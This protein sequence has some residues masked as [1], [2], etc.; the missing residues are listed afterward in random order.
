M[1]ESY[2]AKR[3]LITL[4]ALKDN[5]GSEALVRGLIRICKERHP[6]CKIV[7]SSG[8]K[9]EIQTAIPNVDAMVSRRDD[10]SKIV[11]YK[12]KFY[13]KILKDKYKAESVHYGDLIREAGKADIIFVIGAD[14]YDASYN[15]Q[16]LM[17]RINTMILKATKG[18]TVMYDC[19]LEEKHISD[20]VVA[21]MERFDYITVRESV[22]EIAFRKHFSEEKLCYFP[23]PAFAMLPEECQLPSNFTEGKMVGINLSNLITSGN[24]GV[25]A[26]K[27]IKSYCNL[28]GY[29]LNETQL[30]II[31][32]PHVMGNADLSMLR[33]LYEYYKENDRV[34]LI[35][36][37]TYNAAQ[38]KYII[39]KLSYLVTA[40]T[41]ASIAAYSMCVP[42]LVIGYSVKSI[43]IAKDL[44]GTADK[45][46]VSTNDIVTGN[47]LI[48]AFKWLVQNGDSIHSH[49]QQVI[50]EYQEKVMKTGEIM[51]G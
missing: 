8:S 42:T 7:I 22:T 39:S 34:I 18:T 26:D 50:P 11:K 9:G 41:H 40:R 13:N 27:L 51:K 32:I 28:F 5:R 48:D 43:G 1:E 46:V 33:K 2:M 3:I 44:F 36:D 47:E 37:E 23:D 10:T 45:Y 31:L 16:G 6:D 49:L 14:N 30:Q 25:D 4:N 19:S 17:Q 21:D 24:Y 38:L 12:A 29:I 20:D 15:M 35:E